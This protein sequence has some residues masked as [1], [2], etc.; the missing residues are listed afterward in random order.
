MKWLSALLLVVCVRGEVHALSPYQ[1]EVVAWRANSEKKLRAPDGWLS[2]TGLYWLKEG[3]NSIGSSEGSDIR[4][5][6][7][8]PARVGTLSLDGSAIVFSAE[9]GSRV[10]VDRKP[11]N[12]KRKYSVVTDRETVPTVLSVGTVSFGAIDR[13]GKLGVRISDSANPRIKKF[14]GKLWYPIESMYLVEARWV[15]LETPI[16]LSVPNVLETVT[17]E[18]AKGRLEFS[19]EGAT[20]SLYPLAADKG[21]FIIF[22][23]QTSGKGSYGASRFLNVVPLS[24]GR[25]FIDFN[26]A[27]NPPC[28]YTPYATCPL[29]P[30]QNI[31]AVP[32]AAGE[33]A[34]PKF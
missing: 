13:D 5:P 1:R 23:D 16:Q 12:P 33:K 25:I 24:D 15:P 14:P 4:L 8:A 21:Y 26:K 27:Y 18:E 11:A 17:Q 3:P 22:K 28:A 32:V 2:L 31:L 6:K 29:A 20:H 30:E 34:P 9:P 19:L 10:R 7:S